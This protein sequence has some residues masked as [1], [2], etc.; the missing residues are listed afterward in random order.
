[1]ESEPLKILLKFDRWA[2]E[3]IFLECKKLTEP[4]L[5]TE[6]PMGIGSLRK[7]LA[8]LAAGMDWWI[9]HSQQGVIRPYNTVPG[10]LDE[11]YSRFTA[12]WEKLAEILSCHSQEKMEE[13]IV[14]SFDNKEFGKGIL[15][16]R[17]SAVMLHL[18]NHG[19]HHRVPCLNM[20]RHLG[21]HPLPE[22]D[23]IDSHQ[24][25]DRGVADTP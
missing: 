1:M 22:I 18:F 13:V 6:F 20:L 23:L 3:K 10:S 12:A 11:I 25:L 2:T 16:F 5:D 24:E 15:R 9:D 21:V 19:T 8:H 14:D 17:R 4:Q 7:T